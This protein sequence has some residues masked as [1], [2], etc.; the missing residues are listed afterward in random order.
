MHHI[1]YIIIYRLTTIIHNYRSKL[2]T[3]KTHALMGRS[4]QLIFGNC[5]K[6]WKLVSPT[7]YH[8]TLTS[9]YTV[10]MQDGNFTGVTECQTD[11]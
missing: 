1:L 5:V 11:S 2:I 6:Y 3:R 8:L 9:L 7:T 10:A 4:G